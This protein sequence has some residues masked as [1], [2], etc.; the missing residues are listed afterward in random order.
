MGSPVV[1]LGYK[2]DPKPPPNYVLSP[3]IEDRRDGP[4]TPP[5]P[6]FS[7]KVAGW[8]DDAKEE[9]AAIK[10]E[11]W[12]SPKP[13]PPLDTSFYNSQKDAASQT[14]TA[15]SPSSPQA[16]QTLQSAPPPKPSPKLTPPPAVTFDYGP[17]QGKPVPDLLQQGNIDLNHRP[18]IK[19]ADGSSSTIF[20]MTIPVNKDGSP[21][22]G[23]YE[24][25]PAYALVP[26]IA[27]GKFLTADGKI[28]PKGDT[29]AL[30]KLEDAATAYYAKTRQHL[31]VFK[32]SR[33]AEKYANLTH[34][35]GAD[36]TDKKV[37]TP[38][39]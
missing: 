4:Q 26:S 2:A 35:Y 5:A 29:A 24:K 20:S 1:P 28:P 17:L 16:V 12:F 34:A 15:P 6:T 21:W 13:E 37:Y 38:S 10:R 36:G 3:D 25:A 27:N 14:P 18:Q 32:S 30:R 19:N 23:K 11:P 39:Y 22:K 8:K 33:A 7:D 31:G 9:W